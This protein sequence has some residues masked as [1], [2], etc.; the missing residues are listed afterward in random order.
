MLGNNNEVAVLDAVLESLS[1]SPAF[2]LL[3][4]EH[5]VKPGVFE[6]VDEFLELTR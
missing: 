1:K 4:P 6:V 5:T 3:K 2:A